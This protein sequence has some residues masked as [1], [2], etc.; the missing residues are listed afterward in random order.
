MTGM[1]HADFDDP[2]FLDLIFQLIRNLFHHFFAVFGYQFGVVFILLEKFVVFCLGRI[3]V[4]SSVV[5][6]AV[7]RNFSEIGSRK[8]PKI[9]RVISNRPPR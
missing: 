7:F 5:N 2:I 1:A 8:K 9:M 3:K 4:S 6:K